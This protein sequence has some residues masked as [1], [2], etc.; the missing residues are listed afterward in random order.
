MAAATLATE[1]YTHD[2]RLADR[3]IC[4]AYFGSWANTFGMTAEQRALVPAEKITFADFQAAAARLEAS[5][6]AL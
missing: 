6:A 4:R 1:T 3:A 2:Q 5:P